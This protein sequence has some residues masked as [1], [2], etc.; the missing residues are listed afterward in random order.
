MLTQ[1]QCETGAAVF[2][3]LCFGLLPAFF[4]L[5]YSR[6]RV[7]SAEVISLKAKIKELKKMK[8]ECLCCS[9]HQLASGT[10]LRQ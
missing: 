8:R 3:G 10:S 7:D 6:N 4:L 5:Q 2:L 9:Q 1:S